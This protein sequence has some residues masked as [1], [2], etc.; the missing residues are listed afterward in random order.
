MLLT[1]CLIGRVGF[2]LRRLVRVWLIFSLRGESRWSTLTSV[3][4]RWYNSRSGMSFAYGD[5]T[6]IQQ[7]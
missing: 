2:L 4:L 3:G 5:L 6:L 7:G 1:A